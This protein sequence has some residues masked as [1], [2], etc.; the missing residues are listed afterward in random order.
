LLQTIAQAEPT[1]AQEIHD[2]QDYQPFTVSSLHGPFP[3]RQLNQEGAYQ[4]R[5]TGLNQAVTTLLLTAAAL[6]NSLGKGAEI[7]LDH[8]VFRVED[9]TWEAEKNRQCGQTMYQELAAALLLDSQPAPRHVSFNF[10]SPTVFKSNG[11][12]LPLPLP[13]M[14]IGSLLERWNA[15]ASIA[16]S[17][18]TRRYAAECLGIGRFE[19]RS[20]VASVAG[21]L[22]SG[23]VGRVTFT[24]LNYDRYWMS[25]IHTLAKFAFYAGVGAKT[26]MGL[27]QCGLVESYRPLEGD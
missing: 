8:L 2:R 3:G 1:L 4:L 20:R 9:L 6:G 18:D 5:L 13:E 11:K 7:E 23:F 10:L 19:L 15:Y 12:L 21:G 26:T 27:G 14:V 22:Y 25:L 16:F 17:P 24:S